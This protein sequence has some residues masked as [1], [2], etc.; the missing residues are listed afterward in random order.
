MNTDTIDVG[1]IILLLKRRQ[2][3]AELATSIEL[4][5]FDYKTFQTIANKMDHELYPTQR[6][7]PKTGVSSNEVPPPPDAPP[8]T[9][10]LSETNPD[11]LRAEMSFYTTPHTE[12]YRNGVY[13]T[14]KAIQTQCLNDFSTFC[15]ST[16]NGVLFPQ[17]V[18]HTAKSVS[19]RF[20]QT[21][22]GNLR[23]RRL[24]DSRHHDDHSPDHR[25]PGDGP[26][27]PDDEDD[28]DE[29]HR[30]DDHGDDRHHHGGPGCPHHHMDKD[31]LFTGALG[32]GDTGDVCMTVNFEKLS[33]ECQSSI[34]E[35]RTMRNTFWREDNF[36]ARSANHR[37]RNDDDNCWVGHVVIIAVLLICRNRYQRHTMRIIKALRANPALLA[38]GDRLLRIFLKPSY[39]LRLLFRCSLFLLRADEAQLVKT[40]TTIGNGGGSTLKKCASFMLA[41]IFTFLA[42]VLLFSA[43]LATDPD[44]QPFAWG[45]YA[46]VLMVIGLSTRARGVNQPCQAQAQLVALTPVNS[47][48][49]PLFATPSPNDDPQGGPEVKKCTPLTSISTTTTTVTST[50]VTNGSGILA[51]IRSAIGGM[52]GQS[53][54]DGAYSALS[55]D[56]SAHGHGQSVVVTGVPVAAQR[57][58]G[59]S[60]N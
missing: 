47:I 3:R 37:H 29:H 17:Q 20:R 46:L 1:Y 60:W 13:G 10:D 18:L 5:A 41:L 35:L 48:E 26:P 36:A 21:K 28:E 23:N 31:K 38:Q 6:D 42:T 59:S 9:P 2:F 39:Y 56:G 55:T 11:F 51:A 50:S 53:S 54:A 12:E 34:S 8:L 22:P 44:L 25:G 16:G 24:I 57:E 43:I 4:K 45:I 33:P 52:T 58:D 15:P 49:A 27:N 7:I 14:L 40:L 19:G 32:Y 30:H